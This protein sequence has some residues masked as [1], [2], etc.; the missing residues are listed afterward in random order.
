MSRV[1]AKTVQLEVSTSSKPKLEEGA[2]SVLKNQIKYLQDTTSSIAADYQYL[3][4]REIM[5]LA[6][7]KF[8]SN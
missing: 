7:K 2:N 3:K 4:Q 8:F 5:H 6:S 1:T